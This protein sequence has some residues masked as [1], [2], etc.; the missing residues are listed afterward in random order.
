VDQV[1]HRSQAA[2]RF[3]DMLAL[4][5]RPDVAG[6]NPNRGVAVGS[7]QHADIRPEGVRRLRHVLAVEAK[8]LMGLGDRIEQQ[9]G[10]H[11]T[12][13]VEAVFKR[14]HDAEIPAAAAQ[15]PEEVWVLGVAR[16]EQSSIGGDHIGGAQ[17]VAGE[18][19]EAI[20]PAQA[21]TQREAGD[22]GGRKQAPRGGQSKG[23][24]FAVKVA[25]GEPGFSAHGPPGR[26][27][28]DPL[29]GRQIKH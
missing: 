13:R 9:A 28:A 16:G 6:N 4:C 12:D 1:G 17:V 29:H 2:Q 26:V 10:E 8:D 3:D 22:T 25:P 15:S 27:H 14:R 19:V 20:E 18:A 7:G 24:R 21:A 23:L 11:G 5:D